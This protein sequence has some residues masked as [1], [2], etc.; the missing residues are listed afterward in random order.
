[1]DLSEDIWM[2]RE[3]FQLSNHA[4]LRMVNRL[5]DTAYA[6][7]EPIWR[8][9]ENRSVYL[10]ISEEGRYV[11]QV[12]RLDG[13]FRVNAEEHRYVFDYESR[14]NGAVIEIREPR[15]LCFGKTEE[16]QRATLEFPGKERVTLKVH[17]LGL[18]EYSPEKLEEQG[19]ILF[20]PFLFYSFAGKRRRRK[21]EWE[22]FLIHD[23]AG[24]LDKGFRKGSLTAFDQ[25]R[26]K[27]LCRHMAWK[28]LCRESWMSDIANQ[29]MILHVLE[30]DLDFLRRISV[31]APR[32]VR[33]RDTERREGADEQMNGGAVCCRGDI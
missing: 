4:L 11:F 8:E 27:Q 26:M 23:V 25:Q 16:E 14:T 21:E 18:E 17:M 10:R 28:L 6:D 7:T 3:I 32:T 29:E 9:Q 22:H 31:S 2:L 1:M 19:L 20:L 30:A 15:V 33:A 12:R 5:F 13:C 24:A